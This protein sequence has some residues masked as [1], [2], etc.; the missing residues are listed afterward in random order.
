MDL[1]FFSQIICICVIVSTRGYTVSVYI[2]MYKYCINEIKDNFMENG[3]LN[4]GSR[5]IEFMGSDMNEK[6]CKI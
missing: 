2:D 6:D 3:N 1:L 5:T 4:N